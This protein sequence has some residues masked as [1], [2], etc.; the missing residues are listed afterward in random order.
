[1]LLVS[2]LPKAGGYFVFTDCVGLYWQHLVAQW[3]FTIYASIS[4]SPF[5]SCVHVSEVREFVTVW[6]SGA[7]LWIPGV[8][9]GSG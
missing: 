1:M 6:Y 4:F 5:R 8:S 2:V 7:C 9:L 3:D